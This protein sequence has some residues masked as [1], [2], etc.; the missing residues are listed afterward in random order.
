MKH[1]KHGETSATER[2]LLNKIA[3]VIEDN[4]EYL[5]TVETIDNGK[6]YV[7]QWPLIFP[8]Q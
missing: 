8:W 4:L 2:I 6:R 7:K 1:F 3:Q 5:A